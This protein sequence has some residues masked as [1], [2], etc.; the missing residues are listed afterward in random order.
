MTIRIFVGCAASG[1]DAESLAVLEWSVRK[2]ASEPVEFHWM[3]QSHD[4]QSFWHG[5][6]TS[7]WATPF[8]GFRW[9]IP[10]ACQYEG[11]AIYT[12]SDVI[13]M[14][15][16]AQ[17]WRQPIPAGKVVLAKPG[18]W[19]MC[20]SLWDC[21]AARHHLPPI[22]SIRHNPASHHQ[23]GLR[24][25]GPGLV[26]PFAGNW[27]CLDGEDYADLHDPAIKAIH[28][29]SMDCQ[30]HLRHA[31]PRLAAAG[32][33]HWFDGTVRAH[34]RPD[35]EALFDELLAEAADH[36]F[37]PASY[38]PNEAFGPYSKASLVNYR[39]RA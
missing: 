31:L 26:A 9:G 15:D 27:N 2:H 14:A 33:K 8:S 35:V 18:S 21:A 16:V 10:A 25:R 34:P 38:I 17:L 5:W 24:F 13:F 37:V 1:E 22:D 7:R 28:Y 4:Q 36:G 39:T 12:D 30:P 20:V 11:R 32:Q 3:K 23:I 19:R 6:E 29:T